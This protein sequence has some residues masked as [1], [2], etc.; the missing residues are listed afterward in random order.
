MR[1]VVEGLAEEGEVHRA[2]AD[3]DLF[4]IAEAVFEICDAVRARQ[5]ASELHHF[6]GVINGDDLFR[7]LGQKL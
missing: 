3:G 6:F 1:G 2:G 5:I 7:T 4:D